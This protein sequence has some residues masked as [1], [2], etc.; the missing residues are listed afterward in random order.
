MEK[1]SPITTKLGTISGRDAF[2]LD[3]V[4]LISERKVELIGDINGNLCSDSPTS[5]FIPYKIQFDEIQYFMMV[6]LDF[7]NY[8]NESSFDE[9]KNS[10]R[11]IDFLKKDSARKITPKHKHFVFATYDTVFEIIAAD[12]NLEIDIEKAHK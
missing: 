1:H 10:E 5:E 12:F 9:I 4:N 8:E 2:Y 11:I 6:E 7:W 3:K